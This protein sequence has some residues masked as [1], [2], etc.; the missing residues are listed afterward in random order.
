M[1]MSC[2]V[3]FTYIDEVVIVSDE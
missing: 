2:T 1:R 3:Q